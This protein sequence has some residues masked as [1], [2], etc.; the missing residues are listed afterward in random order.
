MRLELLLVPA[1]PATPLVSIDLE[2]A[3]YWLDHGA[4]ASPAVAVLMKKL[5]AAQPSA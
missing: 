3:Q 2:R 1:K 4:Q 5:K